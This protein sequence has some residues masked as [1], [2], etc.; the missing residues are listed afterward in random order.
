MEDLDII[1]KYNLKENNSLLLG[2]KIF[3]KLNIPDI[4]TGDERIQFTQ[5]HPIYK[6]LMKLEFEDVLR[7]FQK[8]NRR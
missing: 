6:T 8:V 7:K 4:Y 5:R 3:K 2:K 1:N